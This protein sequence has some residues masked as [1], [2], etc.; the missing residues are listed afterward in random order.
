[1][2]TQFGFFGLAGVLFVVA[3]CSAGESSGG[4]SGGSN[5]SGGKSGNSGGAS[6]GAGGS[7]S[8]ASDRTACGTSCVDLKNDNLN[9][10]MCG[11]QCGTGQ[12]CS[13]SNCQCTGGLT[14]CGTSCVNTQSDGNNC[15][16]CGT[17]CSGG[18]VCSQGKCSSSCASNE[19]MCGNGCANISNDSVNCGFC[20]NKCAGGQACSNGACGCPSG[21]A[22][23][24]GACTDT[25]TSNSHCGECGKACGNGQTCSNGVCSGGSGTGGST[26]SG[27]NTSA[28][29]GSS[30]TSGGSTG[31]GGGGG[32]AGSGSGGSAG[33]TTSACAKAGIIANFEEG[34]SMAPQVIKQEGRT[35]EFE[36]FNDATSKSE[37]MTVESSGGTAECDKWALRVKGSGY[38]SW[39]AG[40]GFSLVGPTKNPMAYNAQMQGFTGIRFKAKLGDT[41]DKSSPVR[42]NISIPA[43]ES[44]DNVGGQCDVSKLAATTNKPKMDCYQHPGRFLPMGSGSGQLGTSWQTFSYCFDRDLYPLSLPSNMSTEQ[45]NNIGASILKVQFQFNKGKNYSGAYTSMWPVYAPS[46]PF[47]FWLDDVEFFKGDCP[48]TLT[49]PSNGSPAKPFPQNANLGTCA[50]AAN[51]AKFAANIAQAYAT[52]QKHFVQ[53]D[54]VVA[55]EQNGGDITSE[56]LGYG[57]MIAAAMGDKALFDKFHSYVRAQG[58]QGSG[59]MNWKQGASGSASDGDL[60]IAYALYMAHLQWPSAGYKTAADAMADAIFKNDLVNNIVRGGSMYKDSPFNPSY[61]SPA[62]FRV[63]AK[64]GVTSFTNAI[65]PNFNFVNT[66]VAASAARVPT[67]WADPSTGAPA[68]TPSG[69]QVQSGIQ[70]GGNGAMGYDAARVPW[71]LGWDVCLGGG[72][73]TALKQIVDYFAAKYDAGASID[74]MLAGWYKAKDAPFSTAAATQGSY[75][76]PMGVGGLAMGNTAMRDRAFRTMLDILESGDFNHTYFPSTVGL[77]TLLMLSGNFPTP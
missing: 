18:Q 22:T 20:G 28:Q 60:D 13:N 50:P 9:C 77:L 45:R 12:S 52:W 23:C 27:G 48:N 36:I 30:S 34:A 69:A 33:G 19:Q 75:I 3:S 54:H 43:T 41:A 31:S 63:F 15:G 39:G 53:N 11:K 51:A 7:T 24:G 16:T 46:L 70:D 32:V 49:S 6:N 17:V 66:N 37:T 38:T 74:L 5:S 25:K 57:M 8:C 26:G 61:F 59:L 42:F 29:G 76:G 40:V 47:D 65:T 64:N 62:A 56:A 68:G 21:Q 14:A 58:G 1:M 67:D 44:I 35:G 73:N 72:N 10:G 71:R 4:G 2:R 55:P